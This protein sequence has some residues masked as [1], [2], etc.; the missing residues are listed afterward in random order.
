MNVDLARLA[1]TVQMAS[2]VGTTPPA[3]LLDEL[4]AGLGSVCLFAD[5]L[6]D[7]GQ[8]AALV[9]ELRKANG[10]VVVA[11]DEEG[12]DVTRLDRAAG[13]SVPGAAALGAVDDVAATAAAYRTIGRRLAAAGIDL[14]LAPVADVNVAAENPVIGVRS[15]GADPG[16]VAR[17]VVAAVDALQSAAVAA[18]L[19]HFPGHGAT[20]ADSHVGLPV[21]D[22]DAATLR[23]RE[24]VPF[25]A[26]AAAA[27][28]S[29]HIVVPA[30]DDAP[31]TTSP[32]VL[33]LLRD[34]LGFDG[35]IISDAL[36]M[37][38][39]HGPGVA[40]GD[41]TAERIGAAAVRALAAGCDLLCLGARQGPDVPAAVTAAVVGAVRSGELSV[42]RLADAARRVSLLRQPGSV[43][44]AAADAA[45]GAEADALTLR[46]VAAAALK[47]RNELPGSRAGA[48]VV[49][50]RA[51]SSMANFDV[52]WGLGDDLAALDPAVTTMHATA[53]ADAA[54]LVAAAARRPLVVVVRGAAAHP[55]QR[56]LLERLAAARP[57]LTAVELGW[58]TDATL[59]SLLPGA[60][61]ITS[62]G[63]SRASTR[64]VARLLAG[65]DPASE[66]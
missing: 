55:W 51:E 9:A 26:T 38:G 16:L 53:D 27:V 59:G 58:P 12:G 46:A 40:P 54:E 52:A 61:T 11:V 45:A 13:S 24:L 1:R 6:V 10:D 56:D 28:M 41:V 31:A 43:T 48:L 36:D 21:V 33:G 65:S 32:K 44:H 14:D 3:W 20:V 23:A 35:A 50:C 49:E 63:A 66:F 7:D 19:K 37:A 39:V 4:R 2:F 34:E 57:D 62:F 5:N 29:A 25:D 17:H 18:C 60:A 30:L 47:V 64:A 8:I 15:F 42:D 22:A